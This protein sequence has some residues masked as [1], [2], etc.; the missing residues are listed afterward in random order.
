[1]AWS[2]LSYEQAAAAMDVPVG[3]FRSRVNRARARLRRAL[4]DATTSDSQEDP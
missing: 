2:E 3:T 1:V 4:A